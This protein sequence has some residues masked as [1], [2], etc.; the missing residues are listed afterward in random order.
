MIKDRE[1]LGNYD[2][3][4]VTGYDASRA[5]RFLKVYGK[6]VGGRYYITSERF[7]ELLQSGEVEKFRNWQRIL[8]QEEMELREKFA[9]TLERCIEEKQLSQAKLCAILDISTSQIQGY[10]K[11]EFLPG[12]YTLYRMASV[13]GITMNEMMGE[14]KDEHDA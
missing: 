11:R 2:V 5:S 8:Q 3:M 10:L 13:F 1:I 4:L 6:P 7:Q 12:A 14:K 9:N